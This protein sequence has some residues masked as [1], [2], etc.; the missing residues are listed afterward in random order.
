MRGSDGLAG[1]GLLQ[2]PDEWAARTRVLAE[3]LSKL[4]EQYL[5]ATAGRGL[6]VGCQTGDLTDYLNAHTSLSWEGID[7][8]LVDG[9]SS[10]GGAQ[11]YAAA[12]DDIPYPDQHFDC[13]LLANVF[14][15]I[16]PGLRHQSFMEMYRVLR[17]GSI[18]VGQLPN[19]YFPIESHSRL[20]FMGW[21][22]LNIQKKYW[23]LSPV[24]WEHDFFTVTMRHLRREAE[25]VGFLVLRVNN[26]NYPPE[27]LP[28]A[29]RPLAAI[30]NRPMQYFPWAW[31]FVLRRP[32]SPTRD[33]SV[34]HASGHSA[35]FPSE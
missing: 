23:R 32:E 33:A 19:P 25:R 13:L 8:A 14:E 18:V 28:K 21:L 10:P 5:P 15:H 6:D 4:A 20:P 31:Q 22:P 34:P 2:S 3:S 35:P 16:D 12:S 26:F 30:A 1:R 11:L 27:A 24:P 17:P 9:K 7:P 29:A